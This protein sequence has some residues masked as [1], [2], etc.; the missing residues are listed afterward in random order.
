MALD[1]N[2]HSP[3]PLVLPHSLPAQEEDSANQMKLE[4]R[5][6]NLEKKIQDVEEE[7]DRQEKARKGIESLAKVYT[8]QPDFTDQKGAEDVSRQLLEVTLSVHGNLDCIA[9]SKNV[10]QKSGIVLT[11]GV[12]LVMCSPN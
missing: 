10:F 4:R 2:Q 3:S 8:E 7:I 1:T 12:F 6:A 9:C 11:T 5:R